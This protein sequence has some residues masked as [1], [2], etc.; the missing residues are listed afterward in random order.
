VRREQLHRDEVLAKLK[1][2]LENPASPKL[3]QHIKYDR[4]VF[5][6]HGIEVQG[7][8]HD[9]ML[10]SYVLEV[11]QAARPGAAWPSATWG[12]VASALKTCAA[13]ARTRSALTRWTLPRPAEYA[14]EDADQTLDVHRAL[15]PQIAG[16]RQAAV[17]L[18]AGD[19]QQRSAVPHRAQRRADRRA[20]AGRRK[21]TSWA[22]ASCSWK[23]R[24]MP[25]PAS[26]ST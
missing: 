13:R 19:R 17:H 6:N 5:A 22:S 11:A 25:L 7:Y 1:P 24:P 26:P 2:W 21:A 18:R 12:A 20:H 10:Q 23:P 3:G 9:T 16:R 4:H 8:A 15:W 14:C